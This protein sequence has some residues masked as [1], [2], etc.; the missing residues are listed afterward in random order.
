MEEE[1]EEQELEREEESEEEDDFLPLLIPTR[2]G[3][4]N[5]SDG[6]IGVVYGPCLN[7]CSGHG[8]C[9]QDNG[10]GVSSCVCDAGWIDVDCSVMMC[11]ND[12]ANVRD[13]E[14]VEGKC[15]VRIPLDR[16]NSIDSGTAINATR[17][18]N[19]DADAAEDESGSR[20]DGAK[21]TQA[22]SHPK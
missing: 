14:C 9:Q 17:G 11:P 2:L 8:S 6:Q 10:N 4:T 1:A 12:C 22:H 3:N 20:K 13:A 15:V 21:R 7:N 16:S 19:Q 18:N 5:K